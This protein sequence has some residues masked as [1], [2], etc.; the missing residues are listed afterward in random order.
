M[1]WDERP[2]NE[3]PEEVELIEE[4]RALAAEAEARA[5]RLEEAGDR[6]GA[7]KELKKA[8]VHARRANSIHEKATDRHLKDAQNPPD[9]E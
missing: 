4:E 6:A 8:L 3:V 5:E 1:S 7:I 9:A 2:E